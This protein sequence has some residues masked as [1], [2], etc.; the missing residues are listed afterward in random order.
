M[1]VSLS[2]LALVVVLAVLADL[3]L[4]GVK[5][6]LVDNSPPD[7]EVFMVLSLAEGRFG[8][9]VSQVEDPSL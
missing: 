6:F 4:F 2:T 9:V 3:L 7:T 1:S 8:A 5:M